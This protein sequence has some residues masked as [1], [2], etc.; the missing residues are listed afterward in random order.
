LASALEI[1]LTEQRHARQERHMLQVQAERRAAL[2]QQV[3]HLTARLAAYDQ[4]PLLPS[5][6]F[7]RI[8]RAQRERSDLRTDLQRLRERYV[9]AADT[10]APDM[11]PSTR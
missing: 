5:A 6:A 4:R 9:D 2:Q 7:G 8:Q 1:V 11:M 3:A 10:E